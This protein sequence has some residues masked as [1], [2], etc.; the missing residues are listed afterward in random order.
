MT[1]DPDRS[2]RR[3]ARA[4]AVPVLWPSPRA[5]DRDPHDLGARRQAH[6]QA[7]PMVA[8]P[9][10]GEPAGEAQVADREA[11]DGHAGD[12]RACG[13]AEAGDDLLMIVVVPGPVVPAP[14]VVMTAGVA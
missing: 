2:G 1:Y 9:A 6:R 11:S 7:Q 10:G 12:R 13:R 8:E 3:R 14:G 5:E 4:I